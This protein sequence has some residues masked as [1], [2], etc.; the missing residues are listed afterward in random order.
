M[1]VE[2]LEARTEEYQLLAECSLSLVRISQFLS[3]CTAIVLD[4]S[5]YRARI[6]RTGIEN[7]FGIQLQLHLF[8]QSRLH[9]VTSNRKNDK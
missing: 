8:T 6:R 3:I 5:Q 1:W 4:K 9:L 7:R 2:N